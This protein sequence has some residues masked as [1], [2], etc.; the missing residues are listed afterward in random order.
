M[1]GLPALPSNT[2]LVVEVGSTGYGTSDPDRPGDTD[3]VGVYVES[4]PDVLGFG[5]PPVG[6]VSQR[7]R[8]EGERSQAGDVD[9]TLH[10]LRKFTALAL[11]GNPTL[12]NVFWAPCWKTSDWKGS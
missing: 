8:P 12:L 10:S 3:L 4:L 11:A 1:S 2:I 9:R 6:T 5:G 7:T